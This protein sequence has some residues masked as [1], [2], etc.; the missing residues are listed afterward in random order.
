MKITKR[1]LRRIIR[2]EKARLF[3]EQGSR[4]PM[5]KQQVLDQ[6]ESIWT[7]ISNVALRLRESDEQLADALGMEMDS[8][9]T[10]MRM[11]KTIL[12]EEL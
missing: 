7:G 10:T 8:L 6:L 11:L 9:D 2:E 4:I 5:P 1:Q 12:P 3:K